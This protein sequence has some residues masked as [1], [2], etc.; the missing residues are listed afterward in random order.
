VPSIARARGADKMHAPTRSREAIFMGRGCFVLA[1]AASC[2]D[3]QHFLRIRKICNFELDPGTAS[4]RDGLG[5]FVKNGSYQ[6]NESASWI[7]LLGG[8]LLI[9][10]AADW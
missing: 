4:D 10:G 1:C 2:R 9:T 6:A 3:A 7:P 8:T 5:R